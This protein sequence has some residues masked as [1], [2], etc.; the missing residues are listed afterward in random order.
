MLP[1]MV[2]YHYL[3]H[4]YDKRVTINYLTKVGLTKKKFKES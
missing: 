4:Y 3:S 1:A 2:S